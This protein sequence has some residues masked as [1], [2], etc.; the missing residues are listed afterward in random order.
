MG[1]GNEIVDGA[2]GDF[3]LYEFPNPPGIH[4]DHSEVAVA[5]DD[6]SGQPGSFSVVFVWGDEDASNNGTI[7]PSYL[8]EAANRRIL[9]S[10]LHQGTGIGL[11]IGR[12]DGALYRFIRIR[13]YEPSASPDRSHRAQVDAIERA[14]FDMSREPSPT[15][16]PPHE[17]RATNTPVPTDTPVPR[18][19]ETPMQGERPLPSVTPTAQP[20]TTPTPEPTATYTPAPTETAVPTQADDTPTRADTPTPTA[21][22]VVK[23]SNTPAPDS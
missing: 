19:T 4:L 8:P 2:G 9:A 10:D 17:P 21:T 3:Y 23:P 18:P 1:V 20:T 6:G 13:T 7:L 22:P 14:S 16:T 11:D 5:P 12:D 15:A